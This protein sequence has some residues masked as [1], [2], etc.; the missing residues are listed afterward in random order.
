MDRPTSYLAPSVPSGRLS[1][2][3]HE[4]AGA[5]SRGTAD[6]GPRDVTLFLRDL[7]TD[8]EVQ[9]AVRDHI[10]SGKDGAVQLF[11]EAVAYLIGR[12]R[13][14]VRVDVTPELARLLAM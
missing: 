13:V 8:P 11:L 12:P 1:E 7:V 2:R 5:R 6:A 4:R 3:R 10:V 14:T 9:E